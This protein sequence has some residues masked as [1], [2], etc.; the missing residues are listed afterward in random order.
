[1]CWIRICAFPNYISRGVHLAVLQAAPHFPQD[2]HNLNVPKPSKDKKS[3][4]CWQVS[5][6]WFNDEVRCTYICLTHQLVILM[7][8]VKWLCLSCLLWCENGCSEVHP[9][10][11]DQLRYFPCHLAGSR[12]HKNVWQTEGV[13]FLQPKC[14]C[15]QHV[16]GKVCKPSIKS[17]QRRNKLD[18]ES[19]RRPFQTFHFDGHIRMCIICVFSWGSSHTLLHTCI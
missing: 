2:G 15:G 4:L 1:M 10:L 13:A 18:S 11:L 17:Q 7:S 5:A 19:N 16:C 6:I 14:H 8:C 9:R 12:C 3:T